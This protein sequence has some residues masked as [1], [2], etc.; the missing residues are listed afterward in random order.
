MAKKREAVPSNLANEAFQ[1]GYETE[2]FMN[3]PREGED[4]ETKRV[5]QSSAKGYK[6]VEE[7]KAEIRNKRVQFVIKPSTNRKLDEY[8]EAGI[9]RSK[10]DLVNYLLED[11]I[12]EQEGK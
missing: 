1:D 3:Q 10:N 4:L 6:I 7:N 9:I 2:N 11:F 12:A 8:A 5:I